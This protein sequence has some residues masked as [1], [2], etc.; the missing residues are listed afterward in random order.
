MGEMSRSRPT[1]V[2]V[3]RVAGTSKSVV[4]RVISGNGPVSAETRE[5][6]E[7]AMKSLG[8]R[9][10]SAGRSL[11]SGRTGTVGIL[12][13][14]TLSDYYASLF[15][16]LQGEAARDGVRVVGA[17]GNMAPGSE[18]EALGRLLDL[19]VDALVVGSG[20]IPEKTIDDVSKRIPTV[21][22]GRPSL[23]GAVRAVFDDPDQ[24]AILTLR[25]LWEQGH[26][27]AVLLD[28]SSATAVYR[29]HELRRVA[30][31]LGMRLL[32]ME[33]GYEADSGAEAAEE[34]LSGPREETAIITLSYEAALGA[35]WGL[36][37]AGLQVPKDV[38]VVASD[39]YRLERLFV[40][41]VSGTTRDE[42]EFVAEVWQS[43]TEAM[44]NPGRPAA[45]RRLPVHWHR[46]E[47][48]GPAR[49]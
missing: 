23:A 13:R 16:Q 45:A 43:L 33:S 44:E 24:H 34:W 20:R 9:A 31:E 12:L 6:V 26:R 21:L 32:T 29:V 47:T 15:T 1:I 38:S 19:G 11:A 5:R 39:C 42:A 30:N 25:A 18:L 4:S 28:S 7:D 35:V 48:L 14:N 40:P 37:R 49:L 22:V 46:G 36:R 3:A 10:N 2:D 27:S 17:T 8:Y 41:D